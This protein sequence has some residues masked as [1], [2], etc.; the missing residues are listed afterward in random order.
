LIRISSSSI[1]S[2]SRKSISAFKRVA[3]ERS[4]EKKESKTLSISIDLDSAL[5]SDEDNLKNVGY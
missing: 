3:V 5:G 1:F 4:D 2:N